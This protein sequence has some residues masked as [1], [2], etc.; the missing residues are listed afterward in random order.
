MENNIFSFFLHKTQ[1]NN[2]EIAGKVTVK[3]ANRN[4]NIY[5]FANNL[6]N[7]ISYSIYF[8]FKNESYTYV[9]TTNVVSSESGTI[10]IE[11]SFPIYKYNFKYLVTTVLCPKIIHNKNNTLVGFK[12]KI[13]DWEPII[14][15][16]FDQKNSYDC[17]E[18]TAIPEYDKLINSL[19]KFKLFSQNIDN[20]ESVKISQREFEYLNIKSS[21]IKAQSCIKRTIEECGYITFS[22]YVNNSKVLY[23]IGIPDQYIPQRAFF[24]KD[25]GVAH[26]KCFSV[27]KNPVIGD[28]GYWIIYI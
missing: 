17:L 11:I 26:F 19:P 27:K 28:S 21:T 23:M 4:S 9:Q 25:L 1:K 12:N 10:D 13:I 8:I 6:M 16:D 3:I 22:R 7:N 2:D 14:K 18:Y 5:V 24:M 20:L 15:N